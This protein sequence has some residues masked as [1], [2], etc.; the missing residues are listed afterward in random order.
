MSETPASPQEAASHPPFL[1][2][3]VFRTEHGANSETYD[4]CEIAGFHAGMGVSCHEDESPWIQGDK[5]SARHPFLDDLVEWEEPAED[6]PSAW[7]LLGL[8]DPRED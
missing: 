4:H 3:E 7:T 1:F 6:G 2:I 5:R 8:D